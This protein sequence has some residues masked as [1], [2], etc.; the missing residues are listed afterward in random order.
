MVVI[1]TAGKSTIR[2]IGG[3]AAETKIV[4]VFLFIIISKNHAGARNARQQNTD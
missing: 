3:G 4:D 2:R 1:A